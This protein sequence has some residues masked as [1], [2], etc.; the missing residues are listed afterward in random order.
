[1]EKKRKIKK[2]G[3]RKKNDLKRKFFFEKRKLD[4]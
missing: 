4:N 1:M 2:I 3:K